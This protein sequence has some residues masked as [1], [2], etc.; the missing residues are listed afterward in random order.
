MRTGRTAGRAHGRDGLAL[1]HIFAHA[2]I[3]LTVMAVK[4][5]YTAAMIQN[6]ITAIAAIPPALRLYYLT[7]SSGVERRADRSGNVHSRM[8]PAVILGNPANRSRPNV[9]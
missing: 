7:G 2:H 6:H 3:E 5:V 9:K 8:T 1:G 4:R